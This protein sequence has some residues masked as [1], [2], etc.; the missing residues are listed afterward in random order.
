MRDHDTCDEA[1][2][3]AIAAGKPGK[4]EFLA[5]RCDMKHQ[6]EQQAA[7]AAA[8]PAASQDDRPTTQENRT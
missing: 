5:T 6:R 4:A 7:L 8:S 1:I 2:A 3:E